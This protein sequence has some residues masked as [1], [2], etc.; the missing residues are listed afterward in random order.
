MGAF[1]ELRARKESENSS[2]N[3]LDRTAICFSYIT[4]VR[5]I[6]LHTVNLRA[7]PETG[8]Q[9]FDLGRGIFAEGSGMKEGGQVF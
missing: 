1:K 8:K 6:K 3:V 4:E 2:R 9:K 5:N 7:Q